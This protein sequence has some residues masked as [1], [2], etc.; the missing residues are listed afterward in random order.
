M[1]FSRMMGNIKTYVLGLSIVILNCQGTIKG[2]DNELTPLAELKLAVKQSE[3]E[4]IPSE[5]RSRLRVGLVWLGINLPSSWCAEQLSSIFLNID[6]EQFDEEDE[7]SSEL[8]LDID[9]L[10]QFTQLCRNPLGVSPL[11]AGPSAPLGTVIEEGLVTTTITFSSLPPADVLIG[12]PDS[13]VAYA[14]LVV[15]DDLNQNEVLDIGFSLPPIFWGDGPGRDDDDD[16]PDEGRSWFGEEKEPDLLYSASFIDLITSHTRL[17]FREGEFTESFFY[18]LGGCVPPKG[19]SILALEGNFQSAECQV[20]ALSEPTIL[21]LSEP[22]AQKQE[23]I[24]A[25]TDVFTFEPP[26]EPLGEEF[27]LLCLSAEE[28]VVSDKTQSCKNLSV[29]QL[30]DCPPHKDSCAYP[31]WDYRDNPPEWWPCLMTESVTA[32]EP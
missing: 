9:A 29:L 6:Q 1:T 10:T 21:P 15:F 24:C 14:S 27:E 17:V 20:K 13:R 19:F 11:L 12:T 5:V 3:L 31:E 8:S 16:G 23:V 7:Q 26:K 30:A 28:L 2:L 22:S 25:A 4:Q 32:S 18:P